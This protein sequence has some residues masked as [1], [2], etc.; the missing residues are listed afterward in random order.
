MNVINRRFIPSVMYTS[1]V[2]VQIQ[3]GFQNTKV[4][5]HR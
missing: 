2:L 3:A 1:D 4:P 5:C